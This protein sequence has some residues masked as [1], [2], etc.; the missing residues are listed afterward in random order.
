MSNAPHLST[1]SPASMSSAEVSLARPTGL[2]ETTL[3]MCIMNIAGFVVVDL[4]AGHVAFQVIAL[5]I[6]I[7]ATFF[8]LWF[9]WKGKNW[10]RTLVLIG[11][12]I[13]LLNLFGL[14]IANFQT[15]ILIIIEA[16][17]ALFILWWLNTANVRAYFSRAK[18]MP[19]GGA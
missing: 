5:S 12:V 7:I 17:F 9:Y 19:H 15:K 4:D 16:A 13:A 3:A 10:A 8:I 14:P 11:A 1:A 6:V 2:R 18:S